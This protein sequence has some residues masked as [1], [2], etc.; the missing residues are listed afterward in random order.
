[1]L[2]LATAAEKV[3]RVWC[4]SDGKPSL[5]GV[6]EELDAAMREIYCQCYQTDV[7]MGGVKH[8]REPR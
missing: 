1:M 6:N 3:W 2:L 5:Q 4:G 7:F 8:G